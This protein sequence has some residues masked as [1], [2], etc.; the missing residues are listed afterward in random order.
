MVRFSRGLVVSGLDGLL[1]ASC[2]RSVSV[3]E[4]AVFCFL[5]AFF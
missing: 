2:W 5:R 3:I 4:A 1:V